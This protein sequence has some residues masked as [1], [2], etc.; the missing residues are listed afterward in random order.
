MVIQRRGGQEDQTMTQLARN[1]VVVLLLLASVGTASAQSQQATVG[2]AFHQAVTVSQGLAD[3]GRF[4]RMERPA[5]EAD[6]YVARTAALVIHPDEITA[7]VVTRE[8][9][10]AD[11]ASITESFRRRFGLPGQPQPIRVTGYYYMATIHVDAH[12]ARN[13][14]TLTGQN[15]GQMVDIRFNGTRLGLPRIHEAVTSGQIPASLNGWTRGQIEQVFGVL[16]P[17]LTW[18]AEEL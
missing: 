16:G 7:V 15:V 14:H 4:E 18:K 8:P 6:V 11:T 12:A 5:G 9:V 13:V 10:Y 3:P 17:K 1:V 2:L